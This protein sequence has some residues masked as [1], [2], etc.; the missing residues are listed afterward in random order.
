MDLFQLA[1]S[2]EPNNPIIINAIGN[3]QLEIG[4]IDVA[5]SSFQKSLTIDSFIIATF[6]CYGHALNVKGFHEE[7]IK[8]YL[9][10]LEIE[11]DPAERTSLYYN[12][13]CTYFNYLKDCRKAVEFAEK[14]IA[15]SDYKK[16]TINKTTKEIMESM[17]ITCNNN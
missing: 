9:K 13:A 17:I 3:S 2:F 12:L 14:A 15:S 5:I 10:G 8:T 11:N 1:D 7:S 4:Q 6:I 16:G